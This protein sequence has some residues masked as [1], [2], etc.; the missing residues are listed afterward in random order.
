[1]PRDRLRSAARA[2]AEEHGGTGSR[3]ATSR[4]S[5]GSARVSTFRRR[6]RRVRR[7]RGVIRVLHVIHSDGFSGVERHVTMLAAAEHDAA[8]G[9]SRRGRPGVD[10]LGHRPSGV[11]IRPGRPGER[12]GEGCSGMRPARRRQPPHDRLRAV[13]CLAPAARGVPG[14]DAAPR[15]APRGGAIRR[16]WPLAVPVVA[17]R[18][19]AQIAVTRYVAD[20]IDGPSQ[21]VHAGVLGREPPDPTPASGACCSHSGSEPEKRSDVAPAPPSRRPA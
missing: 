13:V 10:G 1:M 19:A 6:R 21:F 16:H 18:L 5:R 12:P 8:T 17:R 20:N 14:H 7:R 11:T 15:A 3:V 2:T 9:S 4:C